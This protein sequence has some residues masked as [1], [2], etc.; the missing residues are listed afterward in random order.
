VRR[1]HWNWDEKRSVVEERQPAV[2]SLPQRSAMVSRLN[3]TGLERFPLILGRS[4][5]L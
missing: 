4:L 1:S 2:M 3:T 5:R